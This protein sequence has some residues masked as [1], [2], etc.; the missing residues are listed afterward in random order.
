MK[1]FRNIALILS[2][3]LI[4]FNAC[5]KAILPQADFSFSPAEVE[6]YDEVSFTN[7]SSDAD[8]FAW[9]FGDGA[10]ST[11][12][13]PAHFYAE[14]GTYTVKLTASNIDGS[15]SVTKDVVV[16]APANF[17]SLDDVVLD[18]TSDMFWFQSGMGGDPYIRLL[19]TPA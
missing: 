2:V 18:I 6:I 14:A 1:R 17:Y 5:E 9:E 11:E 16:T 8:S 19:T 13:N 12:E 3:A 15:K 10:T 7:S 4:A